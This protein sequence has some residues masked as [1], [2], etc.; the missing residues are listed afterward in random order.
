MATQQMGS[1]G[2]VAAELLEGRRGSHS[3]DKKQTLL[4]LLVLLLYL[5]T[6]ISGRSWEVPRRIRECNYPQN[7]VAPQGFEYHMSDPAEEPVRVLRNWV[8]KNLH[9]FLEKLEEEVRELEQL[10]RDVESW[11]DVVLGEPQP[12][13]E[14]PCS[15]HKAHL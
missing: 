14:E 8:K 12:H 1:R 7:P 2:Q 13:P 11:L 10:V 4:A 15:T 9:V 3:E 6:G 5:T